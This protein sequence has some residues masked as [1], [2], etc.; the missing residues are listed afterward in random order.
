MLDII[1]IVRPRWIVAENVLGIVNWSKGLVFDT[2]CSDLETNGYEIQPFI[3]PACGVGAPHRRD[4]IWFIAHRTDTRLE[5]LR[6]RSNE[7][8][9]NRLASDSPCLGRITRRSKSNRTIQE[10]KS[11]LTYMSLLND[12]AVSGLLPTPTANDAVNS[13]IPPSQIDRGSLVGTLMRGMLPTPK[14]NDFRSGM[15]NRVGTVHTQQLNDT[16]A[17]RTGKTSRLN[18]LFVEEMMGFP[19]CWILLPFCKIRH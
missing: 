16:I 3:I 7:V 1:R 6:E 8:H 10:E 4:R 19:T 18:P 5:A 11:G 9:A 15:A 12:L 17:Y 13:S 14:A 2:V